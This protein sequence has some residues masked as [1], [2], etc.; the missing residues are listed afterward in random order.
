MSQIREHWSSRLG[1]IMAAAGS[2]IG[3]GVLWKFPYTVG[4]NGG[5]LFILV[6]FL[7]I[8]FVGIPLF[9][10]ELILGRQAQLSAVGAFTGKGIVS[11][12]KTVGWIAVL[13]SFLIMSY[14]SVIAG[15]CMSY[16]VM[17]LTG[18]FKGMSAQEVGGVFDALSSSGFITI[19]WHGLF[20][21]IT[22]GI[23]VS[24]VRKGIEQWS[25]MMTKA[26][27]VILLC[28]FLYSIGLEGFGKAFHF[29]F[30]PDLARFQPTSILEALGLAFFTLSLGQG[31]MITY[32]SYMQKT[33]DIPKM[34]M[35]IGSMI[36]VV[37]VLAALSIFPVVFTFGFPAEGGSGLVFKTLPY[38]FEQLPGS[39]L[40]SS[41]FFVLFVFCALTSAVP[42]IEVV[43]ATLI[44]MYQWPRTRAALIVGS[45]TFLFGLPSCL[46]QTPYLSDWKVIYGMD[47]LS[48]IDHLVTVWLLP[49]GGWLTAFFIG[50]KMDK[51]VVWQEFVSGTSW[52]WAWKFWLFFIRFIVPVAVFAILLQKS[53][54]L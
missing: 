31:I 39:V 19:F 30:Y 27:L 32:G 25:K 54:I 35:I 14:Y 46:A 51:N 6:Y 52:K 3:L 16:S 38:L 42:L 47:F 2:A 26:L 37:A 29:V 12:W 9:M 28:L 10:G 41:I 49:V 17:S 50:W 33:E 44:D 43:A 34:G 22:V 45:G 36:I 5:G 18:V 4:N 13:S 7:C 21:A 20:T 11:K 48:T 53:G 23:V 8:L 24:G 1:F 40:L 15:W